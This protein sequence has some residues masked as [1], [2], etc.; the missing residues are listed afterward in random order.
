ML[1]VVVGSEGGG[2]GGLVGLGVV[3]NVGMGFVVVFVL[4][5]GAVVEGVV[6]DELAAAPMTLS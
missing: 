4:G 1:I 6:D 3:L 5:M 2:M